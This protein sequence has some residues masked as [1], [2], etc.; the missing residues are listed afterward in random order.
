[1]DGG[2]WLPAGGKSALRGGGGTHRLVLPHSRGTCIRTGVTSWGERHRPSSA[3]RARANRSL[4]F[5]P[6]PAV[7]DHVRL[8]Q[9]PQLQPLPLPHCAQRLRGGRASQ[10]PEG[11]EL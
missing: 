11:P 5:S 4:L 2:P 6:E 10:L 3:R 7:G 8:G 1:M 9:H